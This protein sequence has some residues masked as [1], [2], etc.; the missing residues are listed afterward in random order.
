MIIVLV[1][2]LIISIISGFLYYSYKSTKDFIAA[3]EINLTLLE[4]SVEKVKN[5][6]SSMEKSISKESKNIELI[7][8]EIREELKQ[9]NDELE[10]IK[11]RELELLKQVEH[12]QSLASLSEDQV[13]A[14]NTALNSNRT[15]DLIISFIIGFFS[16]LM[17]WIVSKTKFV[18]QLFK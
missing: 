2:P 1:S 4:N 8:D 11:N 15:K 14:V 6:F 7:F 13:K 3:E 5:N 18:K 12:Y 17:V 10:N 9:K 16:S